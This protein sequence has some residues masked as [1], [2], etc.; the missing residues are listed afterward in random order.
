LL[1]R[2]SHFPLDFDYASLARRNGSA[3]VFGM[4]K[5]PAYLAGLN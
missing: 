3:S 1:N 4:S 2:S 5:Q